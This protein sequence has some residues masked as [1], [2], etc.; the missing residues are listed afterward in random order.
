MF[1]S[2]DK[3]LS[4]RFVQQERQGGVVEE[5]VVENDLSQPV[6]VKKLLLP[7]GGTVA[8]MLECNCSLSSVW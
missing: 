8:T 5:T 3:R 7:V 1:K 6:T 2:R 4:L